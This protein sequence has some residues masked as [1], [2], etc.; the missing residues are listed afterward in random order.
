M[1]KKNEVCPW[2][3]N[4]G[5]IVLNLSNGKSECTACG[6]IV[7][8][9][10]IV[11]EQ[12]FMSL[13]NGNS[14]SLGTFVYGPGAI[15]R[16]SA[17][18]TRTKT[19]GTAVINTICDN[20]INLPP[21]VPEQAIRIFTAALREG[22]TR[23]RT[24]DIVSAAAVYVAIRMKKNTGYFLVD[25]ADFS[26]I[27]AYKLAGTALALANVTGRVMPTIDPTMYISR[28]TKQLGF[29][30]QTQAV[31]DTALKLIRRMERDWIQ[32]GRKPAGVCVAAIM[33]AARIHKIDVQKEKILEIARVCT[34]TINKR[35]REIASTQ[36]ARES[37]AKIREDQSII[38]Q[39]GD[40]IP[41][42]LKLKKELKEMAEQ[43]EI[44]PEEGPLK[45]DFDG[46]ELHD[47]DSLI[48]DDSEVEKR[49]AILYSMYRTKINEEPKE[50]KINRKRKKK[51]KPKR[52][53]ELITE[54]ND[55]DSSFVIA[56][57]NGGDMVDGDSDFE[58]FDVD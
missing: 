53:G 2:C 34:S 23:G 37:L 4:V 16:Y 35:L 47:V 44:K 15:G 46:E 58:D 10:Q 51:E 24:I 29:G 5:T 30:R 41:P 31:H 52:K 12:S 19:E 33:I 21:D 22:F 49:A 36:L 48:I 43:I 6:A 8:E 40:E 54:D 20:L 38:E 57:D 7:R 17:S 25:V 26:N 9:S 3:H 55:M 50:P 28:F 56:D 14:A 13:A 39:T 32:T 45:K 42:A 27:S 1:S 18:V 11:N